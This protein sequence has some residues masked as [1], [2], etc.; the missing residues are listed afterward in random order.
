MKEWKGW[1]K[2]NT[3][4]YETAKLKKTLTKEQG[5]RGD[6]R[7][8]RKAEKTVGQQ[9]KLTQEKREWVEGESQEKRKSEE[10]ETKW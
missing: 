10:I 7:N 2:K 1:Q 6:T 8:K 5:R 9:E 4:K 3:D